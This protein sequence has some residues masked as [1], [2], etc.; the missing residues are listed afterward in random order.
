VVRRLEAEGIAPNRLS[1]VGYGSHRPVADN[2][3]EA[4]RAANRRVVL[5]IRSALPVDGNG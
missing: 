2:A 3:T 1:A 4:G 5:R